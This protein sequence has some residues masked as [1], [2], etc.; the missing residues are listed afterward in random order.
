ME[1]LENLK[2]ADISPYV[3]EYGTKLLTAIAVLIIGFWVVGILS[4]LFKK[5]ME[6]KGT[7][8]SLASFLITMVKTILKAL[9]VITALGMMGIEMTSFIAVLG[10]LAFAIGMALTGS[11]QNFAGGVMLLIFKPFKVGD[12][13]EAQGYLGTVKEI[14]IFNTILNTPDNKTVIIP[15]GGLSTGSMV[16]YSTMDTR[17]VDWSFGIAYGDQ[18]GKAEEVLTRLIKE[19]KRILDNPSHFIAL[20]ALADSSVN[21]TVRVWVKSADY[22]GV[23]FDMN[24]KVYEVFGTEGLN[25]PFPQMDVHVNNV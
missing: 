18:V 9:V 11:L 13:L 23:F 12:L 17:R 10:A 6:K 25:F 8:S 5:M 20:G 15:N 1:F 2:W 3:V 24:R 7:D 21:I 19:D 16:N 4:R 22:W 14:Q